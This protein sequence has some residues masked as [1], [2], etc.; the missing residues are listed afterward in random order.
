MKSLKQIN[1]ENKESKLN[2]NQKVVLNFL[3]KN[4][5]ESYN[6][7]QVGVQAGKKLPKSASTWATPI[8]DSLVKMKLA[9]KIE[10]DGKTTY[11]FASSATAEPKKENPPKKESLVKKEVKEP[12][13]KKVKENLLSKIDIEKVEEVAKKEWDKISKTELT[14]PAKLRHMNN[15]CNKELQDQGM[16]ERSLKANLVRGFVFK[17]VKNVMGEK[18][19]TRTDGRKFEE[20]EVVKFKGGK[21]LDKEGKGT[22]KAIK[23]NTHGH[24]YMKIEIEGGLVIDKTDKFLIKI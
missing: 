6:K 4:K 17:L 12:K 21:T 20:G 8:L 5:N 13:E 11:Q 24:R 23:F 9:K 3:E 15:T 19:T 14:D 16:L 1:M 10:K 18:Y 7:T 2:D 22:I